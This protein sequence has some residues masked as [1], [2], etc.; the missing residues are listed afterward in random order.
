[1][2]KLNWLLLSIL[3]LFISGISL[4]AAECSEDTYTKQDPVTQSGLIYCGL[5]NFYSREGKVECLMQKHQISQGC[6]NCFVDFISCAYNN[7]V[8]FDM[9]CG[10]MGTNGNSKECAKCVKGK[11]EPA[12]LSCSGLNGLPD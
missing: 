7:C 8:G 4:R 6:A 3:I 1:M 10:L 12:F 5:T 9:P 11:C 2:F